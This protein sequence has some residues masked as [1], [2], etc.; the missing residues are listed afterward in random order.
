MRHYVIAAGL[1][2]AMATMFAMGPAKA[3]FGGPLINDQGLCRQFGANNQNLTYYYWGKCP[4]QLMHKGHTHVVHVTEG[5]HG[6]THHPRHH[7]G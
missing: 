6:V 7:H 2:F 5:V 1:A 3:E 4:T